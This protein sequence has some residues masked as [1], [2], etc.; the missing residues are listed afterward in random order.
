MRFP[1]P[2]ARWCV[3]IARRPRGISRC[4]R[5]FWRR[6]G[7]YCIH[8]LKN[9][10]FSRCRPRTVRHCRIF[11][12]IF[13]WRS[14]D[15]G[16]TRWIFI[17]RWQHRCRRCSGHNKTGKQ[18][19]QHHEKRRVQAKGNRRHVSGGGAHH[20]QTQR[21]DEHDHHRHSVEADGGTGTSCGER[22]DGSATWRC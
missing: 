4:R 19:I 6:C 11:V 8:H 7:T 15:A 3:P 21:L 5:R 9:A 22:V 10:S 17:T 1:P 13:C 20:G 18:R 14:W 2:R 16:S 12:S